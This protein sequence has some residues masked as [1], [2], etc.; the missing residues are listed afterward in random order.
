MGDNP[1]VRRLSERERQVALLVAQDLKDAVIARRLG[2][3]ASTVAG[4]VR[5]VLQ[6]LQLASRAE[7]AAWVTAR[8]DPDDPTGVLR[9]LDP[10]RAAGAHSE[11]SRH[12]TS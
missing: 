2:L 6:R 7:I 5:H 3:S 10:T 4:Y 9:R 1:A 11:S 8:L 12:R